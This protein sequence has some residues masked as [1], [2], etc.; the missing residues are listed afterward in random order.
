M[1]IVRRKLLLVSINKELM[2]AALNGGWVSGVFRGF[3][4]WQPAP[5]LK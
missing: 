4:Y 1:D 3:H 2:T 5:R